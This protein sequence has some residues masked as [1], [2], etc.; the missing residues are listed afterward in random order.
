M[1]AAE[2]E[3]T[4]GGLPADKEAGAEGALHP[5]RRACAAAKASRSGLSSIVP[6]S[7]SRSMR[8]ESSGARARAPELSCLIERL[9]LSGTIEDKPL[10]DAFAAAQARRL[11]C[12]APSAPASLSAGKPPTVIS[13]SAAGMAPLLEAGPP[14]PRGTKPRRPR[15]P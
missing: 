13:A 8:Q 9:E 3:I 2:A 4:V 11:G 12:K 10:R 1:P 5:R 15:I 6:E 7:S 14:R